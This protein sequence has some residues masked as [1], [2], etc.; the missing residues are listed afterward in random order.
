MNYTWILY[1]VWI[2]YIISTCTAQENNSTLK[3]THVRLT[4]HLMHGYNKGVRPVKDWRKPINVY[5]DIMIYAV[6]GVDEKN[7]AFSTY[8]WYNQSWADEFLTWDPDKFD[9][10]TKI[11]IPTRWLWV[12]DIM[13]I[14]LVDPGKTTE[15][16]Y[17][18]LD[19]NGKIH[20]N[21]PLQLKSTCNF[22]IYYFPFDR[23]KCSM[24]FTSWIH[25]SMF[26]PI[27]KE[28][29]VLRYNH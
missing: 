28:K 11:S 17:V 21:K 16:A 14:E 13:I 20:N 9:N 24:T 7:Q 10:I 25:T 4:E 23:H 2:L 6:L 27:S 3:P 26:C 22:D 12:P 8:I 19:Y 29:T 1:S 5:V 18:Y 15:E